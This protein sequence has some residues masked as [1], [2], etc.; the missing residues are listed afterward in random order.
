[1]GRLED[2]EDKVWIIL[3]GYRNGMTDA[4]TTLNDISEAM[5][6]VENKND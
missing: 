4:V 3:T 6:G 2:I 1:L 5:K